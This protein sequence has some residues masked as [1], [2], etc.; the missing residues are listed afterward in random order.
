MMKSSEV[1]NTAGFRIAN[2][3]LLVVQ[4]RARIDGCKLLKRHAEESRKASRD[5]IGKGARR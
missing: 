2:A 4:S 1:I 3:R 5:L